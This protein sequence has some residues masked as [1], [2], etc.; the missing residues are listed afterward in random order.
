[1]SVSELIRTKHAV[2]QF[3][4]EPLPEEAIRSILN[5]GRRAQSSK[6]TQPWHFIAIRDRETLRQLSQCGMYAG[7]LAG[8]PFAIALIASTAEGFDLGQAAASMQLAAWDLG[9][10][11]CIASMWEP[12][13]AKAILGVPQDLHFDVAI[14][15]GYPLPSREQ[16]HAPKPGGRKPFDEV[17][18]RKR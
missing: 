14:S 8:A 15:F 17:V 1:M 9:I 12:E 4:D 10:G 11:S 5:A 18:S 13:Q 7:H 6:N 3:T 16:S 2:R